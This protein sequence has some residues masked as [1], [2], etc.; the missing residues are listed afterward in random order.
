MLK[1]TKDKK[2]TLRISSLAIEILKKRGTSAQKEFDK[3]LEKLGII[4]EIYDSVY[5]LNKE[6][7]D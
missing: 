6:K 5:P 2:V 4:K 3:T 7:K 1:I